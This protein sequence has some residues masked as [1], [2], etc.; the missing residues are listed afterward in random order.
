[1]PIA[2]LFTSERK[3]ALRSPMSAARLVLA[4]GCALSR[5]SAYTAAPAQTG[6]PPVDPISA[7]QPNQDGSSCT[8]TKESSV[9][10]AWCRTQCSASPPNCP[11]SLCECAGSGSILTFK[12]DDETPTFNGDEEETEEESPESPEHAAVDAEAK[13]A[14][15]IAAS[16]KTVADAT[17]AAK[18]K[19]D[20]VA[21]ARNAANPNSALKPGVDPMSCK[22]KLK[23][24]VD[25]A[26]C[27]TQCGS[28]PPNC[29]KVACRC[30]EGSDE[31]SDGDS[32]G[33]SDETPAPPPV[34]A[35]ATAPTA[36][37]TAPTAAATAPSAAA[38][39]ATEAAAAAT[40]AAA[41]ATAAA[42][43]SAL[44]P[45]GDPM[46]CVA[47]QDAGQGIDDEWC[48]KTCMVV[49]QISNLN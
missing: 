45:G 5:V 11:S 7:L 37:A 30:G 23:A 27:Q 24:T 20:A 29:P 49:P 13:A 38:N 15:T 2:A 9:D 17:E 12:T 4:L 36:A 21:V 8:A 26:W 41:A 43:E 31:D 6:P 40:A 18:A 16:A 35:T 33:D 1:M 25:T 3:K 14:A 44:A 28:N 39:A 48:R 47:V 22:A 46:G 19:A 34:A 32:D 10:S 42:A